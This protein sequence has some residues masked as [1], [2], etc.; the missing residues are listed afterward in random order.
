MPHVR[1]FDPF[2]VAVGVVAVV[3]I[4]SALGAAQVVRRITLHGAVAGLVSSGVPVGL[5]VEK[6]TFTVE[7]VHLD[8]D[9]SRNE[10]LDDR[11]AR[12]RERFPSVRVDTT[13]PVLRIEETEQLDDIR[14]W[15]AQPVVLRD[16]YPVSAT[17]ALH[18]LV[19]RVEGERPTGDLAPGMTRAGCNLGRPVTLSEGSATLDQRLDEIAAATGLAWLVTYEPDEEPR[20]LGIGLMC[21]DGWAFFF[22]STLR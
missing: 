11:V 5:I 13:R 22:N 19:R 18:D 12:L 8:R 17:N 6:E 14:A 3:S 9:A 10:S 4:A 15:L 16:P 2:R 20:R 21:P 7:A 1:S